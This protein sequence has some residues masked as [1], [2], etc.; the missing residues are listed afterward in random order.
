MLLLETREQPGIG[1][2]GAVKVAGRALLVLD[3]LVV[4]S[5]NRRGQALRETATERLRIGS[6]EITSSRC[7][8]SVYAV[9]NITRHGRDGVT[10]SRR[11]IGIVIRIRRQR[12]RRLEIVLIV[13][14]DRAGLIGRA[15]AVQQARRIS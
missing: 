15:A 14:I 10:E 13:L 12:L 7:E 9:G 2:A 11:V 3:V 6:R 1:V 8:L 4:L 5:G